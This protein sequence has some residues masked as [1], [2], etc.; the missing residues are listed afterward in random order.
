MKVLVVDDSL[1]FRSAISNA[2]RTVEGLEVFKTVSNGKFAVDTIRN[3]PEI[4]LVILDL[5]MPV[6]DGLTAI[7]EIRRFNEKVFI[8]VF[9]SATLKGAEKTM[10]ALQFGANEFVTK[11]VSEEEFSVEANQ[12]NSITNE[13]LPK[14]IAFKNRANQTMPVREPRRMARSEAFV[15]KNKYDLI[16]IGSSTG[17]PDALAKVFKGISSPLKIPM[18]IVQHMPAMFTEKM[19]EMLSRLSPIKVVEAKEG[20]KLSANTCYMAPGDFHMIISDQTVH[21]NQNEKV[22]FVRPSVDVT[23][24]SL[25]SSQ[26]KIAVIIMTGMGEDGANGCLK[27]KQ[28]GADI[29]IQDKESSV[30]WGMPGAVYRDLP[31]TQIVNIEDMP[32]LIMKLGRS[33]GE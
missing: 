26:M 13:L 16:V 22:C 12:E 1:V 32:S 29:F 17:G 25:K 15:P 20:M 8:I 11:P 10:S 21:L 24:W 30:V 14:V 2:L 28:A 19:A 7:Q 31:E 23:L 5:E 4:D 27:L 3:Y 18:L 33:L 9:S 6:M